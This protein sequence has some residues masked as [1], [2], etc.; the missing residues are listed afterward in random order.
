[1]E[2]FSACLRPNKAG[3]IL[4]KEVKETKVVKTGNVLELIIKGGVSIQMR[5][6]V[7]N[8]APIDTIKKF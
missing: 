6:N 7:K 2:I 1:M 4:V 8:R 3:A 5:V